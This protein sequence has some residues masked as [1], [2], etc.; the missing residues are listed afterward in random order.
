VEVLSKAIE[1]IHDLEKTV[2]QMGKEK[3]ALQTMV[4]AFKGSKGRK[5][6]GKDA[7]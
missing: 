6:A 2:M 5:C 7:V 3:K 4:I 1:Y